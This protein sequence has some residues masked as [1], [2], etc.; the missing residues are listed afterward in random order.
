[1]TGKTCCFI[2]HSEVRKDISRALSAAIERHIVEYGVTDFLVGNYGQFDGMAARAVQAA[3][4]CHPGIRLFLMLPYLPEFGRPLPDMEGYDGA[5]YPEGIERVPYKWAI[6]WLNRYMVR[7]SDY[8][9]AYIIHSW[10]G[11][12]ATLE[13]AKKRERRGELT[14][15]NI[16]VEG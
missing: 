10:G 12:A 6:S 8:V 14:I 3:K 4:A 1:M 2:G 7:D 16:G 11:A 15:T 5:I 13:Q 9:I